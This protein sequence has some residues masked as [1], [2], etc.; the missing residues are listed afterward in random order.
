MMSLSA[1]TPVAD[2]QREG[3]GSYST[4]HTLIHMAT[5]LPGEL[6]PHSLTHPFERSFPIIWKEARM[7]CWRVGKR[8]S[9]TNTASK[10]YMRLLENHP[11]V[12]HFR[13]ATRAAYRHELALADDSVAV[14]VERVELR[15]Q[16][17]RVHA[18]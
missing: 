12:L 10:L 16:R 15:S 8:E 5:L 17:L 6:F 3:R 14:S 11:E 18:G 7:S 9:L 4:F 13:M 2:L 1:L